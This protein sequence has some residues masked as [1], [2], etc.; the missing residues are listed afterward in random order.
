MYF[1]VRNP[2]ELIVSKLRCTCLKLKVLTNLKHK[3]KHVFTA[4]IHIFPAARERYI[5]VC[6]ID[7][8]SNIILK[9]AW[10]IMLQAEMM[11]SL[12]PIWN[13]V[14]GITMN[15]REKNLHLTI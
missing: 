5:P 11:T 6:T 13:T 15:K 1:E 2:V 14:A 4:L 7:I 10:R 9:L 3:I 8:N 12:N